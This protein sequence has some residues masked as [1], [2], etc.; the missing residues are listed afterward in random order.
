M[1]GMP[2]FFDV[3]ERL[4]RLSELGDQLEAYAQAV[5][6]EAFRSELEKA[7]A[8]ATGAKGGRPP[9]DPVLMLKILVIQAAN[10]L[11]DERAEFLISDRLSFMRFLGLGLSDR[12]PDARTIWLFRERLP[13]GRFAMNV[14]RSKIAARAKAPLGKPHRG[15]PA[16]PDDEMVAA[17][18][19]MTPTCRAMAIAVSGRCYGVWRG[20]KDGLRPITSGSIA[21]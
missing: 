10:G 21:S 19:A 1:A 3:D 8:H 11:S 6:F 5:D 7:L 20:R 4:K 16:L 2:G 13:Q 14:A 18:Q 15:R 9:Y 12:V 17:I